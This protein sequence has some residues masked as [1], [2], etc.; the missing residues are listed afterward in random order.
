METRSVSFF[1]L[2]LLAVTLLTIS[3]SSAFRVDEIIN[4]RQKYIPLKRTKPDGRFGFLREA[5]FQQFDKELTEMHGDF[6]RVR[7]SV[8]DAVRHSNR[9]MID[10][11]ELKGD[12]H[13]VAFLHWA[14]QKSSVG[15]MPKLS[16][17]AH[18]LTYEVISIGTIDAFLLTN[19]LFSLVNE[20]T[21]HI[22]LSLTHLGKASGQC[23][24]KTP[25]SKSTNS[26]RQVSLDLIFNNIK[27]SE[28][29]ID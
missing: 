3:V 1:F 12:N 2:V 8:D 22:L 27:T 26:K 9:S 24:D 10:E 7:R 4:G 5:D 16:Y 25:F 20:S 21:H 13:T 23:N 28:G 17:V 11:F 6:H 19:I 18:K 15:I 29:L 14:G